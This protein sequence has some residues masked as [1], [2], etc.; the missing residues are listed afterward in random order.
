METNPD[1]DFQVIENRFQEAYNYIY[2]LYNRLAAAPVLEIRRRYNYEKDPRIPFS[3]YVSIKEKYDAEKKI[4]Y[5]ST[6]VVN[7]I[8]RYEF[9]GY[10]P[11]KLSSIEPVRIC[12]YDEVNRGYWYMRRLN[13]VINNDF[14]KN[15]KDRLDELS[16]TLNCVFYNRPDYYP[17]D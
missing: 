2:G 1:L 11:K 10:C 17:E 14:L 3:Y 15:N 8:E 7:F 13:S 16:L 4:Q 9:K 12:S 6:T 5:L